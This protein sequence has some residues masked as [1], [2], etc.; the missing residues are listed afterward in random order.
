VTNSPATSSYGRQAANEPSSPVYGTTCEGVPDRAARKLLQGR[1]RALIIDRR[2]VLATEVCRALDAMRWMVDI[3]AERSSPAFRSRCC[4]NRLVSPPWSE[5]EAF[6]KALEATVDG[7]AYDAIFLGSEE[8]LEA[9]ASLRKSPGWKALL[10]PPAEQVRVTLSKNAAIELARRAGAAIPLTVVPAGEKEVESLAEKLQFPI[11]VKG[12][13]GEATRN[14]AITRNAAQLIS[15]YATIA[16]RERGYGGRPMLQ[17]FVPGPQYSLGGLFDNGEP[18][19]IFAYRKLFT[20]PTNGGLTVKAITERPPALLDGA[21]AVFKALRYTGLGQIQFIR[22]LRDDR[23]KFLEVNP[24]IWAS[25]GLAPYAGVDL[26]TPYLALVRGEAVKPDLRYREG[27][28]YHRITAELRLTIERP[29]HLFSFLRDCLDPRVRSDFQWK[30]P[31]PHLPTLDM[32]RKLF[33]RRKR[34]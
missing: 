12:E 24:R 32:M 8:I 4:Q 6:L 23:F 17:E 1:A 31:G 19:R 16:A 10:L 3:F 29:L 2:A 27:V 33:K 5:R 9:I 14:V 18:L 28:L 15:A 20:Y 7:G 34:T 25:I 26:Y 21:F 13:K 11:V 30:D 22:D